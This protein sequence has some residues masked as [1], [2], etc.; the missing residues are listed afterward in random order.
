M[1]NIKSKDLRKTVSFARAMPDVKSL[2]GVKTEKRETDDE[3]KELLGDDAQ[4]DSSLS[5]EETDT[6]ERK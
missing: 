6:K 2:F 4:S 3:T 5:S 1:K